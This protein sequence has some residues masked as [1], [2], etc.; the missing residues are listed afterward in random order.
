MTILKTFNVVING[1]LFTVQQLL[2]DN[3]KQDIHYHI[4]GLPCS[5]TAQRFWNYNPVIVNDKQ[6]NYSSN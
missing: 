4:I 1:N 2:A 3:G 6:T 5:M